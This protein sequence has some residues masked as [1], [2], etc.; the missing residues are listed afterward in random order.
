MLLIIVLVVYKK[1]VLSVYEYITENKLFSSWYNLSR[2]SH[3]YPNECKL[4]QK[5]EVVNLL[6][7]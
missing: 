3:S 2:D 6:A 1:T 5:T 4:D 7:F